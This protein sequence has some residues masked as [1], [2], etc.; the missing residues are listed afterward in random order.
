M[1]NIEV[2]PGEEFTVTLSDTVDVSSYSWDFGDVNVIDDQSPAT[3]S[4]GNISPDSLNRIS[5]ILRSV[6]T[7]CE[8]IDTI[9]IIFK[10]VFADFELD[11]QIGFC[12]GELSFIN[13]S[14]N[15]TSYSW[16]LDDFNTNEES[17]LIPFENADSVIV[18]LTASD[19][20]SNCTC[21]ITKTIDLE[22]VQIDYQMPNVF[23]PKNDGRN[24]YINV[25]IEDPL[26]DLS[27]NEFKV[28]NRWGNLVYDNDD[29]DN[30]WNGIYK[31]KGLPE[32]VYGYNIDFSMKG[33]PTG[34]LKGNVTIVR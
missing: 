22:S 2:C 28:Y 11:E 29:R 27:I 16:T 5:L 24:D 1:D 26:G 32:G 34:I 4:Y 9:S 3:H 14:K 6:V 23:T 21:M 8:K 7:G 17:P 25:T 33:C 20:D 19:E 13:L 10:N 18:T 31:G 12:E 15:A 30:G